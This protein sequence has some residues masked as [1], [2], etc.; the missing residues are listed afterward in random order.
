MLVLALAAAATA[1]WRYQHAPGAAFLGTWSLLGGQP[2][3]LEIRRGPE[4]F[5]V[6]SHG[7]DYAMHIEGDQLVALPGVSTMTLQMG[8]D[9]RLISPV[10]SDFSQY[11]ERVPAAVP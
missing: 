3:K 5:V 6:R 7:V 4:G 9:G 10:F 2:G 1:W 11:Y 8:A